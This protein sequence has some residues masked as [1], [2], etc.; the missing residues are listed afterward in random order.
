[1]RFRAGFLAL[2]AFGRLV[3]FFVARRLARVGFF[4]AFLAAFF[5]ALFTV[6]A[7]FAFL[8][9]LPFLAFLA[10]FAFLASAFFTAR[11]G[12]FAGCSGAAE[13]A[14]QC[15]AKNA[16]CGSMSCAMRSPPGTS[17][18]PCST[19]PRAAFAF[20]TASSRFGTCT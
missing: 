7:F 15:S 14:D 9:F 2:A 16:P 20:A 17:A 12:A 1:L 3:F 8:A 6:F 19:E 11:R 4:L 13:L 18:G 10:F 5:F